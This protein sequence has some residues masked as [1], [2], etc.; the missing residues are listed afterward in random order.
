LLF[1]AAFLCSSPALAQSPA[2]AALPDADP[3]MWVVKD[4]DTTIYLFGTFHA[5]DG[6]SAWFNDEVKS[7]FDK[8]DELVIEAILP[9]KP[10]E[11][12]PLIVKHGIDTS[13][14]PLTAKLSP[15]GKDLL[16]K[17][18]TKLG[19]Q[20]NA[21]DMFKPMFAATMLVSVGAQKSGLNLEHGSEAVLKTA[22]KGAGKPIDALETADFQLGMFSKISEPV[23]IKSLESTL[24]TMDELPKFYS[25]MTDSWYKGDAPGFVK[26]MGQMDEQSPETY[27]V[28][29]SDR[30]ATWAEWIDN[31]LDRPGTVFVAV[32][33]GHLAGKDSVQDQLSKR[34]IEATRVAAE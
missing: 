9:E 22:A 11:L 3:A 12:Q 23:A 32:G 26:I 1:A 29:F 21:V 18:L 2:P 4:P 27:K 6:K 20:P 19:M 16:A 15:Q 8:S 10:E 34:G 5:L 14:T 24:E 25:Q 33:T 7:A 13:G 17:S 31:R 30:N 28:I